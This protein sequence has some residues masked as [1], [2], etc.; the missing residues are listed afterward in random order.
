MNVNDHGNFHDDWIMKTDRSGSNKIR[1]KERRIWTNNKDS[2]NHNR[3]YADGV[4]PKNQMAKGIPG[5]GIEPTT[6]RL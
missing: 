1:R 4:S 5:T 3:W 6:L 2:D